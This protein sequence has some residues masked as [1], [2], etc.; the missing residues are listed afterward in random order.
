MRLQ[1]LGD[2]N[3]MRQ[4]H[5]VT[6]FH[7]LYF[8]GLQ[9]GLRLNQNWPMPLNLIQPGLQNS[10]DRRGMQRWNV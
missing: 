6:I 5:E 4:L 1:I 3:L 2:P 7:A 9:F 10:W 8:T